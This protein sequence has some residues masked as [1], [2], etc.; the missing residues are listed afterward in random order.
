MS[1]PGGGDAPAGADS[2]VVDDLIEQVIER[3]GWVAF[4]RDGALQEHAG[5]ALVSRHE[6]RR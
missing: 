6:G 4:T 2:D 3:G 5:I 1:A